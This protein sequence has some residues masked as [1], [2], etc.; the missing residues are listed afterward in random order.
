MDR[1]SQTDEDMLDM[2]AQY[3]ATCQ[4]HLAARSSSNRRSLN[5]LPT[6]GCKGVLGG[7]GVSMI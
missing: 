3:V 6:I 1:R 5:L 4:L 2:L 7:G